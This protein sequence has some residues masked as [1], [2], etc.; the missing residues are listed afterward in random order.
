MDWQ[1]VIDR[2]RKA[3]K[4]IVAALAAMAGIED[5]GEPSPDTVQT[6]PR[7]LH[8]AVLRLLRPAE[9]AARRLVLIVARDMEVVLPEP[10]ERPRRPASIIL[11]GRTGTGIILPGGFRPAVSAPP[12]RLRLALL[13]PLPDPSRLRVRRDPRAVVP[14]ISFP[15]L[16]TPVPIKPWRAPSPDDPVDATRLDL[17]LAALARALDDLPG[18]A[19]RLAR[20]R[21]R[22]D[23]AR[24]AGRRHRLSEL[25]PGR[26]YAIHRRGSRRR[27]HDVDEVL[28]DL[29]YFAWEAQERRDTS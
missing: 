13:D 28:S 24:K 14:R 3:L 5:A 16:T 26:A 20:W 19:R 10:R 1:L 27:R 29:H 15:G 7:R 2:N 25:R 18:E 11:R 6:L 17:R 4:R 9:A 8:R 23:R 22:R 21:A 12:Q